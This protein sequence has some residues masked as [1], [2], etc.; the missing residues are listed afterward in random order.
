[1]EKIICNDCGRVLSVLEYPFQ[2]QV[3]RNSPEI[4][5]EVEKSFRCPY[6]GALNEIAHKGKFNGEFRLTRSRVIYSSILA[7]IGWGCFMLLVALLSISH[8]FDLT[9]FEDH[10]KVLYLNQVSSVAIYYSLIGIVLAVINVQVLVVLSKGRPDLNKRIRRDIMPIGQV[11]VMMQ[12]AIVFT[13][14]SVGTAF[15]ILPKMLPHDLSLSPFPLR[16]LVSGLGGIMACSW[17]NG[18]FF[19]T[20][21]KPT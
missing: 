7:S 12:S 4:G 13:L 10:A 8:P 1:M 2:M 11:A 14:L 3:S 17:S 16:V 21:R 18:M 6:C 5:Y 19:R 9:G 20:C 15:L